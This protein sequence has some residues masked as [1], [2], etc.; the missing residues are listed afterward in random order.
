MSEAK[1][2]PGPWFHDD[3]SNFGNLVAANSG[4]K[5]HEYDSG[6]RTVAMVQSCGFFDTHDTEQE[7]I[8]ANISLIAAAP[9]LYMSLIEAVA[10]GKQ[11]LDDIGPCD[12]SVG[13]C[14]C[15]TRSMIEAWETI[16]KKARG[17]A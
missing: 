17:E 6:T 3:K 16:L 7:N 2:T 9:E 4:R 14:V 5:A 13:L 15:S 1:F 11:E 12:H 10:F 8:N